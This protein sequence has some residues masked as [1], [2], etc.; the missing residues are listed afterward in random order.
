MYLPQQ[1]KNI[2]LTLIFYTYLPAWRTHVKQEPAVE[3]SELVGSAGG[4][5]DQLCGSVE[6]VLAFRALAPK[7]SARVNTIRLG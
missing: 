5:C 2:W 3:S 6:P 4:D 7:E 1:H